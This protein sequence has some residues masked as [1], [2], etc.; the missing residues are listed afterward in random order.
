MFIKNGG[1]TMADMLNQ[2][3]DK[4]LRALFETDTI[5]KA[6]EVA[7][8]NKNTGFK[9]LKDETFLKEYRAIRQEIMRQVT[10]RL[11]R[12][13]DDAVKVLE[14]VMH[15]KENSTSSSR[16]QSAKTILDV[17][18]RSIE[19]DDMQERIEAIERAVGVEN[20]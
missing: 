2:R 8:I 6:C 20:D 7:G 14:D 13:S 5:E 11:Q 3:Q 1:E 17:A 10:S 19:M 15:D 18:F 16:V 4:F 12:V 9:Y